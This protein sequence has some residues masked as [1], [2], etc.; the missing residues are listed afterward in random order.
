MFIMK[1]IQ[2]MFRKNGPYSENQLVQQII[3]TSI[4]L[5]FAP[6][7]I[8]LSDRYAF[9]ETSHMRLTVKY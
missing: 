7:K 4:I 6:I 3:S 9:E 5:H 1:L 8:E 2:L